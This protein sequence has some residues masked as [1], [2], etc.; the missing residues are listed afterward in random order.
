AADTDREGSK[1][2]TF[3][4]RD[5]HPTYMISHTLSEPIQTRHKNHH[6][7]SLQY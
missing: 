1:L 5:I 4:T 2:P 7:L 6:K 3:A